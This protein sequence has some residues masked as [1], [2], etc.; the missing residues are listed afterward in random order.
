MREFYFFKDKSNIEKGFHSCKWIIPERFLC[1]FLIS[2]FQPHSHIFLSSHI[3]L[4]EECK[5]LHYMLFASLCWNVQ[6]AGNVQWQVI[7]NTISRC[8][9]W[10]HCTEFQTYSQIGGGQFSAGSMPTSQVIAQWVR[11]ASA[12]CGTRSLLVFPQK[13]LFSFLN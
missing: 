10:F 9:S 6:Q 12:I 3:S 4:L 11:N 8:F 5:C 13:L 2:P 7:Y 1:P